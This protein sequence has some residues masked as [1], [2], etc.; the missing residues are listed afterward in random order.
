MAERAT[1]DSIVGTAHGIDS[2]L[3][4]VYSYKESGNIM[5]QIIALRQ[6]G[7]LY[8]DNSQFME[9]IEIPNRDFSWPLPLRTPLRW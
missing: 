2:T 3:K 5:G 7:K 8:R 1:I 9:A 6:L 4:M